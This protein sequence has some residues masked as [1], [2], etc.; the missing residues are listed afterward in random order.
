[1]DADADQSAKLRNQKIAENEEQR[2]VAGDVRVSTWA[3]A[4]AGLLVLIGVAI[5]WLSLRH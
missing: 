5:G 2:Q 3:I 4:V 1:M